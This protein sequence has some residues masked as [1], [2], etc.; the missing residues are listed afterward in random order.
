[1]V[2]VFRSLQLDPK[3]TILF[4]DECDSDIA[5]GNLLGYTTVLVT[6]GRD[7]EADYLKAR[8]INEPTLIIKSVKN[9]LR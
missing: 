2:E 9:I 8:G 1:M 4:G 5:L 3:K 7:G 6:T